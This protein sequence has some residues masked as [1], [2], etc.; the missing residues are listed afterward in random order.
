[1]KQMIRY[2]PHRELFEESLK[3]SI[4]FHDIESMISYLQE[5]YNTKTITAEDY[6]YDTRLQAQT[7]IVNAV[8]YPIGFATIENENVYLKEKG[9]A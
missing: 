6:C 5:K 1:M 2:R 9:L 4:W 3:E 7:L 8:T